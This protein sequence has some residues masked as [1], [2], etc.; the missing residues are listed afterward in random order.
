MAP[1]PIGYG[2]NPLRVNPIFLHLPLTLSGLNVKGQI[3][4]SSILLSYEV[5]CRNRVGVTSSFRCLVLEISCIETSTKL[6]CSAAR[7][8][9]HNASDILDLHK[10]TFLM[11]NLI[12]FES[13]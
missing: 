7:S 11:A 2:S 10:Y 12:P 9:Y 13:R 1:I 6:P 8:F 3:S 4:F 5:L